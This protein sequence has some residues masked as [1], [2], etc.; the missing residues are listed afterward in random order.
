MNALSPVHRI[1]RQMVDIY[2]LH[3]PNASKTEFLKKSL[4]LMV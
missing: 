2:L 3:A 1:G 4:V